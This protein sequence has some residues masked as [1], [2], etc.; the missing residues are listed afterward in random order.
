MAVILLALLLLPVALLAG[1]AT[2]RIC[3]TRGRNQKEFRQRWRI[4]RMI[5]GTMFALW[6]AEMLTSIFGVMLLETLLLLVVG[7]TP[8]GALWKIWG[9]LGA[10]GL[11]PALYWLG[12]R[13]GFVASYFGDPNTWSRPIRK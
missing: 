2:T 13:F 4:V 1:F 11:Q 10:I 9:F 12:Y 7:E 6:V 5:A 3:L 8:E